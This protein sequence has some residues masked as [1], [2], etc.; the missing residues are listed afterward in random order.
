M[1]NHHDFKLK[2]R[3]VFPSDEI[4]E[5]VLN[6]SYKAYAAFQNT[7][8]TLEIEQEWQWYTPYKSWF[9]K[10]Q[11]FWTT[12]RGTRKEKTLYWL[13]VYDGYFRIAVWFKEKNREE[14][15]G[16]D[17]SE[18]VKRRI[19]DANTMG[20]LPTFPVAFDIRTEET[21]DEVYSLLQYKKRL[22][23]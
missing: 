13:Y 6:S 7:L 11:H 16:T 14:L 5:Q 17:L 20:K 4:L 8:P 3:D 12:T 23:L 22:E 9:A 19:S 2:E 21:L 18:C 15:M 1:E 10:G